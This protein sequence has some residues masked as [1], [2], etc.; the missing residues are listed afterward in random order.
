MYVASFGYLISLIRHLEPSKGRLPVTMAIV[1]YVVYLTMPTIV[2]FTHTHTHVLVLFTIHYTL[3]LL[4]LL[5]VSVIL[6]VVL[7]V[8]AFLS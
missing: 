1:L 4:M 5:T 6:C 2:S 3:C 7:Y 8:V